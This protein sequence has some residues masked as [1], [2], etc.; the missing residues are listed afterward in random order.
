MQKSKETNA[1]YKKQEIVEDIDK[2]AYV[3]NKTNMHIGV[4]EYNANMETVCFTENVARVLGLDSLQEKKDSADYT[5]FKA[6]LDEV[7]ENPVPGEQDVFYLEKDTKRY[8]KIE[9]VTKNDDI[10]GVVMEVT[11]EINKRRQL[12]A[13]RDVDS[14]TGLYNRRGME[15]LLLPLLAKPKELGLGAFIFVDADGLKGINDKYGHS[16]GDLYLKKIAEVLKGFGTKGSMAARFGG[17]EF[18]LFLYHHDT[19]DELLHTIKALHYIQDNGTACLGDDIRVPLR[20]SFGACMIEERADYEGL[21]KI[22]DERMYENKRERK[23]AQ[24]LKEDE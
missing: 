8:I 1:L 12:E 17:D 22:A 24:T 19:E 21:L 5:L 15:N 9:E 11:E 7:R 3:L 13:E 4:Y 6:F 20:F 18:I 2:I 23:K 14:L 10:L 16:K